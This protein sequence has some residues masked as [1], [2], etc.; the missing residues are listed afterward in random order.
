MDY[1][2]L[3]I[4]N[5]R[6]FNGKSEKVKKLIRESLQ[7]II[8]LGIPVDDMTERQKEKMAMAFLAVGNVKN[9]SGWKRIKDTN[10]DYSLTT[11]EIIDFHNS[12]LEENISRGSYDDIRRK[13]LARLTLATIVVNSKPGSNTSNPTRGYKINS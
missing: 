8:C 1:N 9:S 6:T 11:R 7:I 12:N 10:S 4:I 13:D 3:P 2:S 5:C